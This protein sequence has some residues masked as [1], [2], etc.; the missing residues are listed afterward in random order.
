MSESQGRTPAPGVAALERV[1]EELAAEPGVSGARVRQLRW[2]AGELAR[3]VERGGLPPGAG[4]S[5]GG[6]LESAAVESYLE[7]AARGELRRRAVPDP[8]RS[9]DAS[10]RVRADCLVI[11]ARRAGV[12]L[13]VPER[14]LVPEPKPV[15]DP[16]RRG[17]LL[18]YLADGAERYARADPGRVRLLA[19][20]GVVLD[21]GARAG[22]LCALRTGDLGGGSGGGP[23]GDLG[24]VRLVRRPQARSVSPPH[25]EVLPLSGPTRAALRRWLPVREELVA[26][27]QGP[28]HALWVSVRGNHAGLPDADGRVRRRPPG[29]PLMP[30]GLARAYTRTV[31][32]LNVEL[33]GTPGWEPLPRRLEQ[34]RRAVAAELEAAGG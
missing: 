12:A 27:A 17:L 9:S 21:T 20:V 13:E 34:L 3:A 26:A 4:A 28:V 23:G 6:L 25:T 7:L 5:L 1:V 33:A 14:P 11:V 15:V 8:G 19:L 29:M 30:R 32:E 24:E 2:V 16:R 22:E 10:M 31:A 18:R